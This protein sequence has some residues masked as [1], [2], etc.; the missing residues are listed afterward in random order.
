MAYEQFFEALKGKKPEV[1]KQPNYDILRGGLQPSQANM[2]PKAPEVPSSLGQSSGASRFVNFDRMLGTNFPGAQQMGNNL[3]KETEKKVSSAEKQA[4]NIF[5]QFKQQAEAGPKYKGEKVVDPNLGSG[6]AKPNEIYGGVVS[7][8]GE[9]LQGTPNPPTPE[10]TYSPDK[11]EQYGYLTPEQARQRAK[12]SYKGPTR[13]SD[14]KGYAEAEKAYQ[15]AMSALNAWSQPGGLEAQLNELY[16]TSGGTGGSR[17]DTALAQIGMNQAGGY[18]KNKKRFSELA[19]TLGDNSYLEGYLPEVETLAA[20]AQKNAEE[21]QK[22]YARLAEEAGRVST[23]VSDEEM[24]RDRIAQARARA[25]ADQKKWT[26]QY[27]ERD[28]GGET[29]S[30]SPEQEAAMMGYS[31]VED[32]YIDGRPW[33]DGTYLDDE[34]KNKIKKD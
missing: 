26:E 13:L 6:Y 5:G 7:R 14:V 15:D 20:T 21:A 22:T 33:T 3:V 18:D 10:E 34:P 19:K 27:G 32:W 9:E 23:P 2:G 30:L 8:P 25:Q 1:A 31:N 24:E 11:A 16:G 4:K 12:E 17:L 29:A 28:E